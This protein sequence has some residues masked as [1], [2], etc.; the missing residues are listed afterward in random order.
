MKREVSYLIIK[1]DFGREALQLWIPFNFYIN[2]TNFT[3]L[4]NDRVTVLWHQLRGLENE[5][6]KYIDYESARRTVKIPVYFTTCFTV[7]QEHTAIRLTGRVKPF[8]EATINKLL[9]EWTQN[10]GTAWS[11]AI[12]KDFYKT[13]PDFML[14]GFSNRVSFRGTLDIDLDEIGFWEVIG[15]E[16]GA[17]PMETL[18]DRRRL[19]SSFGTP[20]DIYIVRLV[21]ACLEYEK[22]TSL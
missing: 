7:S 11:G 13:V 20:V 19:F 14:P 1:D 17:K 18:E 4:R 8:T 10:P 16:V 12:E 22:R 21:R 3:A 15:T 9:K 6:L 2:S 5:F